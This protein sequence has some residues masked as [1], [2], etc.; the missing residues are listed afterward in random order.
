VEAKER[1]SA[2]RRHLIHYLG[3]L[4][5]DTGEI[6]GRVVNISRDGVMLV[7]GEPIKI[8]VSFHL[9]LVLEASGAK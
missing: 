7:S 6:I 5:G 9:H 4:N 8:G 3:V 2:Q 1:R